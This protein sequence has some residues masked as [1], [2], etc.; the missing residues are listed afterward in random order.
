[1]LANHALE[2][3]HCLRAVSASEFELRQTH[4]CALRAP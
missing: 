1:M 4:Q 3:L 2:V